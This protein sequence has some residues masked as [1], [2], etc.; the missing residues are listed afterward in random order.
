MFPHPASL[1]SSSLSSPD[2]WSPGSWD[3]NTPA[4]RAAQHREDLSREY[5]IQKLLVLHHRRT[6]PFPEH[7]MHFFRSTSMQQP[8][9]SWWM[10]ETPC[11]RWVPRGLQRD[12]VV[13]STTKFWE[14][15]R[16]LHTQLQG[17]QDP[18]ESKQP[19]FSF[20]PFI[21]EQIWPNS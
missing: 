11:P 17:K 12:R 21:R 15:D 4:Y 14:S 20:T 9:N 1:I 5:N 16:G 8:R 6:T 19:N 13:S 18:S 7:S 2:T 3:M 10:M